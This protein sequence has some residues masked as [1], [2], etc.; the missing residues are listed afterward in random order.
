M[1]RKLSKPGVMSRFLPRD[2]A[3]CL[4]TNCNVKQ[5]CARHLQLERDEA[6]YQTNPKD[7]IGWT[8]YTD[9]LRNGA[10][11]CMIHMEDI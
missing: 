3:R 4:G 2:V 5:T 7:S 8:T 1:K 6:H 10:E 9:A 11:T